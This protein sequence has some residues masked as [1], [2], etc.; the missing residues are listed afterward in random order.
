MDLCSEFD[1][2]FGLPDLVRPFSSNRWMK[3]LRF[4]LKIALHF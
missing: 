3:F 2:T 4:V 1:V